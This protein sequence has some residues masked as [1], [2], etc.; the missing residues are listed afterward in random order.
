MSAEAWDAL[1]IGAGP[2]GGIAALVLA[3]ADGALSPVARLAGMFDPDAV[4]WGFAIRTCLP[5]E[6]PLPLI[7][8]LEAR[9][10]RIFPGYGWLFPGADGQANVGIGVAL[11]RRGRPA[12]LQGELA[13]LCARLRSAGD[14]PADALPG[15][16]TGGWLRMGGAGTQ[17]A[18]RNVLLVGD[19]AVW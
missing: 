10:W 9:P 16:V 1:V 6:V 2:A 13:R 7:V 11:G 17:P 14:L 5:A 12:R 15:P 3:R 18:E 4:L 8:L 19:A